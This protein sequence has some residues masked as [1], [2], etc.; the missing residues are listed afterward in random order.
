[1]ARPLAGKIC[2]STKRITLEPMARPRTPTQILE[3]KGAFKKNPQRKRDA[4]PVPTG[5][6]GDPPVHFDETH[7]AA[8]HEL[9]AMIPSG[10]LTNADRLIV[11]LTCTLIVSVRTLHT[12]RGDKALLKSCLATLGMTPADRSKISVPK[13]AEEQDE[14]ALLAAE[15]R[16]LK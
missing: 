11:E 3:L 1:V 16:R 6:V 7:I 13:Q 4:E 12:E 14:F 9:V 10:V 5:P 15:A 2:F 8:W